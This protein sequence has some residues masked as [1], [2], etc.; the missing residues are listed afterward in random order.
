MAKA[1]EVSPIAMR[2]RLETFGLIVREE[3]PSLFDL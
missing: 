2:I 3:S 1:F